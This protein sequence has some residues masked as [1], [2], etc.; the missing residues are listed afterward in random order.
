MDAKERDQIHEDDQE[1]SEELTI[2]VIELDDD[3]VLAQ[4]KRYI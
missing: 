2:D 4:S 3:A 1:L